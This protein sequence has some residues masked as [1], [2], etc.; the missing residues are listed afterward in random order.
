[1]VKLNEL[2]ET[3]R[4]ALVREV[5]WVMAHRYHIDSEDINE[6]WGTVEIGIDARR[7]A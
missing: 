5:S 3:A 6:F 4:K 2:S 7:K 1:M